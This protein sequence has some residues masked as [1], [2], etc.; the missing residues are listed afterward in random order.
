M[1]LQS[2]SA[3]T[4]KAAAPVRAGVTASVD[5]VSLNSKLKRAHGCAPQLQIPRSSSPRKRGHERLGMT[6]V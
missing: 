3:K 5:T 4:K 1:L 2:E 6:K